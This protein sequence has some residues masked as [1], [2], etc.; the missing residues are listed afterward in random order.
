M[1]IQESGLAEQEKKN[2]IITP[3]NVYPIV[4]QI[5][6]IIIIIFIELYTNLK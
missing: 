1:F 5:T 4:Q 2:K 3:T 6:I